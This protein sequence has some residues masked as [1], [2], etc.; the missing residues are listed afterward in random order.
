MSLTKLSKVSKHDGIKSWSLQAGSTCPWSYGD[1]GKLVD[2][3]KGCY[4]KQGNYRFPHVK[5]PRECNRQDWRRDDWVNDMAKEMDTAQYFRWFDSG[6]IYHPALALKILEVIK[7]TPWV[8]HWIPTR[9]Y[10]SDKIRPILY[11]MMDEPNAVVRFSS[12]SVD[13]TYEQ[14]FHGSTIVPSADH[15]VQGV[16]TCG[17]YD[18]KGVCQ[19]CR[20]CWDKEVKVIAYVAHGRSMAKVIKIKSI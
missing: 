7:A 14:G 13:G 20:A 15:N 18:R 4:A 17:A 19:G 6:D 16:Y 10:K 9:A 12:D 1:D 5:H 2:A 3:C 8:K 11:Q